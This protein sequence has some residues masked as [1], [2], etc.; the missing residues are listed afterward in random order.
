VVP[1]ATRFVVE[2]SVNTS[3]GR[4]PSPLWGEGWGEGDQILSFVTPH[5][6]PLGGFAAPEGRG[7][8]IEFVRRSLTQSPNEALPQT[9]EACGACGW[10]VSF[11]VGLRQGLVKLEIFPEATLA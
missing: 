5:P 1:F 6:N 11:L 8:S 2:H 7:N 4:T 10:F 9:D 3:R